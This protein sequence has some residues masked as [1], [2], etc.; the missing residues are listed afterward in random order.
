MVAWRVYEASFTSRSRDE[1]NCLVV[2]S[3]SPIVG[4]GEAHVMTLSPKLGSEPGDD[5]RDVTGAH[6]GNG[7]G[8]DH[9]NFHDALLCATHDLPN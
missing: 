1:G 8:S 2:G 3:Q 7:F 9:Q 4:D 6:E 5:V